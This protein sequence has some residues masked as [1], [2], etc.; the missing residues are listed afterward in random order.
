[1]ND[2]IVLSLQTKCESYLPERYGV[3]GNI[4]VFVHSTSEGDGYILRQLTLKVSACFHDNESYILSNRP[5]FLRD[6]HSLSRSNVPK[7]HQLPCSTYKRNIK[8]GTTGTRPGQI[9]KHPTQ[10]SNCLSSSRRLNHRG[11][12]STHRNLKVLW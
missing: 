1:M 12:I 4:E 5:P 2:E 10:P 9:T 7:C 3:Y 11:I 8:F 6:L